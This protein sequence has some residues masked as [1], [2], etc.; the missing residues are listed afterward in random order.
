MDLLQDFK[1]INIPTETRINKI[2][3]KNFKYI[4]KL[5]LLNHNAKTLGR[6]AIPK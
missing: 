5:K 2:K 3:D 1:T 6:P 4:F